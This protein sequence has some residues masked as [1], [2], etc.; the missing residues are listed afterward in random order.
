METSATFHCGAGEL[1]PPTTKCIG[2]KRPWWWWWRRRRRRWWWWWRWRRWWRIWW[3]WWCW[4]WWRRRRWW[5]DC[6]RIFLH[7]QLPTRTQRLDFVEDR[8]WKLLMKRTSID[9]SS[10]D[11]QLWPLC[12]FFL[13]F[14]RSSVHHS[15]PSFVRSVHHY[16][17]SF[18]RSVHHSIPSFVPSS[19]VRATKS[20]LPSIPGIA[21]QMADFGFSAIITNNYKLLI[22]QPLRD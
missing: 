9:P 15:F 10:R 2:R 21:C 4:R 16:F 3:W 22:I 12:S 5:R 17:P 20:R 18:V 19:T 1:N 13:S 8:Q 6:R 14:V 11:L 7:P